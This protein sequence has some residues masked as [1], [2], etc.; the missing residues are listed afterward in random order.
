M[1]ISILI[2]KVIKQIK[3]FGIT[4]RPL[5]GALPP[6]SFSSAFLLVQIF[7]CAHIIYLSQPNSQRVSQSRRLSQNMA[8]FTLTMEAFLLLSFENQPDF[9]A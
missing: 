2:S 7:L 5:M 3:S 1:F 9:L 4:I 6:N 8:V